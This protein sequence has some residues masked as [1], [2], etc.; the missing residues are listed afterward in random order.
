M[1]VDLDRLL[2]LK[3]NAHYGVLGLSQKEAR[4]ALIQ[5]KRIAAAAKEVLAAP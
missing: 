5:A 2:D 3:D 4:S 1:A